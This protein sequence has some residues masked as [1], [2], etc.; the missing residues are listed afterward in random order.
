MCYCFCLCTDCLLRCP[1]PTS[2][3]DLKMSSLFYVG[4]ALTVMVWKIAVNV[5]LFCSPYCIISVLHYFIDWLISV[6]F[7]YMLQDQHYTIASE[8]MQKICKNCRI[9]TAS[10][11]WQQRG[12]LRCATYGP[13]RTGK[14]RH[15]IQWSNDME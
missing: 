1:H 2:W 13:N 10:I 4:N 7:I 15:Q 5:C 14:L 6:F 11:L 9:K 8:V 3:N 12:L